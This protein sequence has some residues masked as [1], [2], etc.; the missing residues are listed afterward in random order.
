MKIRKGDKIL[1]ISGKD[2]GKVGEVIKVFPKEKKVIV[3]GV[4]IKKKHQKPKNTREKGQRIEIPAPFSVSNVK[5]VC[6]KCSQATR[7]GY[8]ILSDLP[9]GKAGKTKVRF[10]KK[11]QKEI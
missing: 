8:R 1:V 5:L 9:V 6:S 11:C 4:N 2:R 7:I 10:C 3:A